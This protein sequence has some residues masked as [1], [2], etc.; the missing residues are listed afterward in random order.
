[1]K[2]IPRGTPVWVSDINERAATLNAALNR[3]FGYNKG[4]EYPHI[5]VS[6]TGQPDAWKYA[7]PIPQTKKIDWSQ[8]DLDV[9]PV[10]RD[11]VVQYVSEHR[12][13]D[14]LVTGK[15]IELDPV[16]LPKG[17]ACTH[18]FYANVKEKVCLLQIT[19][20][21]EGWEE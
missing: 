8:I 17:V 15:T 3:Y 14:S 7:V 19:G 10:L 1:M 12:E 9:I 6:Q 4:A 21:V 11:G 13:G 16:D 18:G 5:V 2:E 20:I